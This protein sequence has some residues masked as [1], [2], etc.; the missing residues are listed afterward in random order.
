LINNQRPFVVDG[1]VGRFSFQTHRLEKDGEIIYN[2]AE[3]V[4]PAQ[5]AIE[6]Y[7]T[8]GFKEISMIYG[9]T[10]ESYR[11][12]TALINRIRHQKGAT[13]MRTLQDNTEKEGRKLL[14]F[15]EEKTKAIFDKNNFT[16]EGIP[17][18]IEE[19]KDNEV[20]LIPAEEIK[21]A[22]E[23]CGLSAEQVAEI[24]NNRVCY[25][26]STQ[27]VNI[28]IDDVLVKEQKEKRAVVE[29]QESEGG[30][31]KSIA[32]TIAHIQKDD[33]FYIVNGYSLLATLRI[34]IGFLVNND[35][36]EYR[37]QFFMDG[38]RKL[39]T[40]IFKVFS[41]FRNIGI[42]L[43]WYH[44]EKKCKELL[45]MAMKGRQIRKDV[46]GE[47]MPLLWYGMVDKAIK[48][49]SELNEKLIK[50]QDVCNNLINYLKR[51]QPYIPCYAVRKKLGLRN[52]SN[53]GEKMNDLIVSNRQKHNGMSW[54]RSGS[55]AL[56]TLTALKRNKEYVNWFEDGDLKFKLAA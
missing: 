11:E 26:D 18:N 30:K 40:G 24:E 4:F 38:E 45:S 13:P 53:I 5:R 7:K 56:A 35:L 25:E 17:K 54:S 29:N 51:N 27:A 48:Y 2:S 33:K 42:I 1:E 15:L 44:L 16:E 6:K 32:N 34:I 31:R 19:Y 21:E 3:S 46:L 49:L 9:T 12:T 8:S 52:S 43:D 50:N 55:V 41:W 10:K 22:I 47:L 14:D 37:L 39:R 36:L 20:A 28:S 23:S